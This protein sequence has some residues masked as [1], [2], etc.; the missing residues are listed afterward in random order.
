MNTLNPQ[1]QQKLLEHVTESVSQMAKHFWSGHRPLCLRSPGSLYLPK[2]SNHCRW[3]P[4]DP[5][6][7]FIP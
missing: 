5:S 3:Q 1:G 7:R 2:R 6:R 4:T